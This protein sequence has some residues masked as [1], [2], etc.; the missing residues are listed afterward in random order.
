MT[1]LFKETAF[2]KKKGIVYPERV[3]ISMLTHGTI[4]VKED[5]TEKTFVMPEG[6]KVKRG[7]ASVPGVCNYV[8]D[9]TNAFFVNE[10]QSFK[11]QL[12]NVPFENIDDT[13]KIIL[14]KFKERDEETV[15]Y[16][17]GFVKK[18]H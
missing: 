2:T 7:Y 6:I 8:K 3:I 5:G 4:I 11:R 1:S 18:N 10:I 13:F 16:N 12:E 17:T 15:R 9:D 14:N